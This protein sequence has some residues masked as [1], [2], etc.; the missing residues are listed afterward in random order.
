MKILQKCR[1]C[2]AFVKFVVNDIDYQKWQDGM[3]IQDA[4]PGLTP[5]QREILI[6]GVCGACFDTL[7][8]KEEDE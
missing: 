7:L 8:G 4:M 6:S 3:L 5:A 1:V 2:K